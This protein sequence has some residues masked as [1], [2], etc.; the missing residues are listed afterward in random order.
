MSGLFMACLLHAKYT[1]PIA[2][3]NYIPIVL[4]PRPPPRWSG[5]LTT[6]ILPPRRKHLVVKKQ[7]KKMS[8]IP[9]I[10]CGS[11]LPIRRHDYLAILRVGSNPPEAWWG[12][13][14]PGDSPKVVWQIFGQ[15]DPP[16]DWFT[17]ILNAVSCVSP[18]ADHETNK[19]VSKALAVGLYFART[20]HRLEM[21][22]W[23]SFVLRRSE[24]R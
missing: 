11:L 5:A 13:R 22:V 9:S 14:R 21:Q 6:Q 17:L 10:R 7:F 3:P 20:K 8:H 19:G 23:T 15:K 1:T 2:N 24:L 4:S 18:K 12:K 16:P